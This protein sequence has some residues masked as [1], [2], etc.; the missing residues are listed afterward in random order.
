MVT[1][2]IFND[3]RELEV[4]LKKLKKNNRIDLKDM[5][6]THSHTTHQHENI[7]DSMRLFGTYT[8]IHA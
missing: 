4:Y 5:I 7:S 6:V 1:V 2:M 8:V 3:P